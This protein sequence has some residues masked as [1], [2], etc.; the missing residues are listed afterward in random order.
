MSALDR[1]QNYKADAHSF[2]SDVFDTTTPSGYFLAKLHEKGYRMY[3]TVYRDT[4][5]NVISE[6]Q[7]STLSDDEKK[8]YTPEYKFTELHD[9]LTT[10][11]DQLVLANAGSGKALTN[12]TLVLTADGYKP[13]GELTLSDKI[14]GT[15]LKPHVIRGIYPQGEKKIYNVRVASSSATYTISCCEEHLWSVM[16]DKSA[17]VLSTKDLVNSHDITLSPLTAL[18]YNTNG[19]VLM[20]TEDACSFIFKVISLV[21]KDNA[22]L[23]R[24]KEAYNADKEYIYLKS[25]FNVEQ[26]KFISD[27]VSSLIK[28]KYPITISRGNF[29]VESSLVKK[30]LINDTYKSYNTFDFLINLLMSGVSYDDIVNL[31]TDNGFN[32]K[33][34]DVIPT[35]EFAP[36]TCIEVDT[37]DHLFLLEHLIPTHNTTALIFKIMYDIITGEATTLKS[38][39]NGN[40]VRVLDKIFVGTF[41]NTGAKELEERLAH[42]Q[43]SLGYTMTASQISFSTFHAEFRRALNS[44]GAATP[45]GKPAEINKCMRTAINNLGITNQGSALTSED[46]NII[47]GIITYY[48]GRLDNKRYNHTS[49]YDYGLTPTVLDRLVKDFA[50]QRQQAGIMDFE[51]LQELLYKFLYVTPNKAV[52]DYCAN[53]YNYIY[54]DEFQDISQIQYAIV[55]F[56]ARGR[57]WCNR[58]VSTEDDKNLPFYTG[59]ETLGKIVVVGDN[60]QCLYTWRGS[61]NNIIEEAFDKDFR[62]CNSQLSYNYRCPSNILNSIIP[63]IKVNRGHER[64][65]YNAQREGGISKCFSFRSYNAMLDKLVEQIK[66][67]VEEGNSVAILCRTNYDGVI[68]AF[69]LEDSGEFNFSISGQNMTLDSPLPKKLVGVTSLF[70]ARSTPSVRNTLM[71]LVP[72]FAQWKIKQIMNILVNNNKTIWQIPEDD[73]DFSCEE[74]LP[75]IKAIKGVFFVNGKRD[76]SL[77]LKALEFVYNW[78]RVNAFGGD[79]LYC[80]N[81]RA[82]IDALLFILK[83]NDFE[84]VFDFVEYVNSIN[85]KLHAR[86]NNTKANICIATVHEFKGKERD[87]V[88]VWNDSDGVFPSPKTNIENEDELEGERMVHYVACTRAKKKNYVYTRHGHKS[89]FVNEMDIETEEVTPKISGTV[90]G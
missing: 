2:V 64:R 41:L 56:Y 47:G 62:P 26:S 42:W 60:D 1:L 38:I 4:S 55:K 43:E 58:G 32:Y 40:T 39:P 68:P 20:H 81:A 18:L 36:M 54:L 34:K 11:G 29:I 19:S 22:F 17:E 28:D 14:F 10:E 37:D 59:A 49:A 89:I 80:E 44:M 83:S 52:Q 76:Q 27:L 88:I 75:A 66:V 86:V 51:D 6:Q 9:M 63:S 23:S 7:Y 5:N 16:N 78:L 15:D 48:R 65:Q 82:Y 79:S 46:Y 74:L 33:I 30:L 77:E 24:L 57:L 87:T 8:N 61:D 72:R 67:E 70:T 25:T 13:I 12:D 50:I 90:G 71:M 35:E 21:F 31:I 85:E 53:R 73:I 45:I 84:T 3:T 69:I